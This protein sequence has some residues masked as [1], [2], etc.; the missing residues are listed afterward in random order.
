MIHPS[1]KRTDKYLQAADTSKNLNGFL[2][3]HHLDS[4]ESWLDTKFVLPG[5]GIRFGYDGLIGLIPG[6]GDIAAA[7]LSTVFIA[8]AAKLG[9]RKRVI[10]KM[11]ANI[12]IDVVVGSIPLV[13]DLF[14]FAFR[15]NTKNLLLLKEERQRLA[16]LD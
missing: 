6:I 13:G 10:A 4:L 16:S 15:S 1:N 2:K 3:D 12:G 11:I 14:D 9:A 8:D 7:G 5:T